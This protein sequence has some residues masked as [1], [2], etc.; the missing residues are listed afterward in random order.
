MFPTRHS[1]RGLPGRSLPELS[2]F[3]AVAT[4]LIDMFLLFLSI[5]IILREESF[6]REEVGALVV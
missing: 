6:L 3:S 2:K 1:V 4:L 5:N